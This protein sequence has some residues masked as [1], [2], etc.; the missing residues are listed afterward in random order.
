MVDDLWTVHIEGGWVV[1]PTNTVRQA[2]GTAVMGAG[3]AKQA[4][5]RFP[6][7]AARYGLLLAQNE[8]RA[9]FPNWRIVTVPTKHHWRDPS[10]VDLV[11]HA[12]TWLTTWAERTH[13]TRVAVPALGCGLGGLPWA[14][15][16]PILRQLPDPPFTVFPPQQ[17]H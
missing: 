8:P 14:T 1:V 5:D 13:P 9:A 6:G 10:T 7:L 2:D 15:V 17:P 11:E 4:A 12:V 3:L 16:A